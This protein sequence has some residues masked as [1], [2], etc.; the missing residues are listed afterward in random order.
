[1]VAEPHAMPM[2]TH[3]TVPIHTHGTVPIHTHGTVPIHT[4]RRTCMSRVVTNMATRARDAGSAAH[5][6]EGG[7]PKPLPPRSLMHPGRS[8]DVALPT[9]FS[10]AAVPRDEP[11][12]RPVRHPVDE[13][14]KQKKVHTALA[15]LLQAQQRRKDSQVQ[16]NLSSTAPHR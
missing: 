10:A 14:P 12:I 6:G 8:L 4:R 13:Q 5:A 11:S 7:V 9:A 15:A 16:L 3:G 2:L 1:M